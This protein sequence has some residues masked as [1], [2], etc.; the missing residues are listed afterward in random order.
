MNLPLPHPFSQNIKCTYFMFSNIFT[1]NTWCKLNVN[2][3]LRNKITFL[4]LYI[5][6]ENQIRQIYAKIGFFS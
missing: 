3:S 4:I 1:I 2:Y 6:L 5:N